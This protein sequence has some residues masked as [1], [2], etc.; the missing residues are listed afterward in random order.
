[1]LRSLTGLPALIIALAVELI[2]TATL[3]T[4]ELITLPQPI[5]LAAHVL[6]SLL[7]SI[8]IA[9]MLYELVPGRRL[10]LIALFFLI[11]FFLPFIGAA[12]TWL[13][14]TFGA[15]IAR[16]KHDAYEY[17]QFTNN[18]ELPFAA[19][20]DRP[21]PKLDSRGFIEQLQ[22][23]SETDKLYNK[24]A[25]AKNIRNTESGPVLK[26]AVGHSNERIRLVAYQMLDKKVNQ[27]NKEIQRLEGEVT[28]TEG[29]ARAGLHLQIANNYRELLTLEDDEPV[30]RQELLTKAADHARIAAEY[31]PA[32]ANAH[33]IIG[34]LAIKQDEPEEAI[35]A[36]EKSMQLGMPGDKALPYIAEAAFLQRNFRRLKSAI[37]EISPAF[38]NYPPMSKVVEYWA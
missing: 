30:A 21:L 8:A 33:F 31:E 13:S 35:T 22:F 26:S 9:S 23:D 36:F 17:W 16:S 38:R 1:V 15:M 27:L 28:R 10:P 12:G 7:A 6:A 19:P 24:V 3:V 20:I 5:W 2:L 37:N 25:A 14:I 32:N 11:S 4:S 29:T 34:Q 18:A